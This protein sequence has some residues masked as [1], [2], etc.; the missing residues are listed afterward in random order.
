MLLCRYNLHLIPLHCPWK[1]LY[2][3]GVSKK[4]AYRIISPLIIIKIGC[5][6]TNRACCRV[7]WSSTMENALWATEVRSMSQCGITC[8]AIDEPSRSSKAINKRVIINFRNKNA[9]IAHFRDK[10]DVFSCPGQL[11]RWPCHS[12]SESETFDFRA[13][14]SRAEQSRAEQ[15]FR[16]SLG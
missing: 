8:G 10:N 15:W 16:F 5:T 14:Q 13:E 1:L 12:V 3:Q 9:V 6:H 7:F 4:D 11:N 2:L